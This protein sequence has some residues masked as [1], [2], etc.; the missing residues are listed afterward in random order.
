[1][2]CNPV[3][4]SDLDKDAKDLLSKNFCF[5][6]IK[7]E[8]T[9]KSLHGA[10]FT[11]DGTNNTESGSVLAGLQAKYK[12]KD[13]TFT[14]K[15][16]T[17][18]LLTANFVLEDNLVKGLKTDFDVSY[19]PAT[20]KKTAALKAAYKHE[21]VHTTHDLDLDFAGP[22]VHNSMVVGYKGWLLGGQ[23]S[24]D[25]GAK[26]VSTN[27]LSLSY[28]GDDIRIHSGVTDFSKYHGSV[29]H[30][31]CD[32]LSAAASL[33][34]TMDAA[35][36]SLTVGAHYKVD[37]DTFY[38]VKVDNALRVGVSYV[39]KLRDGAEITLSGLFNAKNMNAGGHKVGLSLK[40]DA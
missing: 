10:D 2:A 26:K 20:G 37:S 5:G 36:P 11:V 27:S 1:M 13:F 38:K 32:N 29:H 4:F 33:G 14:E 25:T 17:N 6:L 31:V 40:L 3:K 30:K 24:Y 28:H 16:N 9:T 39:S 22:V 35:S 15:W 19:S 21:Y 34:F 12:H 23:A 8:A 18:N 7:L